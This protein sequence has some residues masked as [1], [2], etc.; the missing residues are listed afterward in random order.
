MVIKGFRITAAQGAK[1]LCQHVFRGTDNER[2]ILLRGTERDVFDMVRDAR[3]WRRKFGFRHFIV[4]PREVPTRD[5]F[6]EAVEALSAEFGFPPDAAVVVGH[7]KPRQDGESSPFHLHVFAPE[8]DPATGRVLSSRWSYARHE[9]V[10]RMLEA[11]WQHSVVPGRFNGPVLRALESEGREEAD[12]LRAEGL[13]AQAPRESAYPSGLHQEVRRRTG[14][15]MPEV[16]EAVLDA[17]TLS[18]GDAGAF[19][20]L[21]AERGLRVGEGDKP[22]RWIVQARGADGS[23]AFAG[24]LD[25]LLRTKARDVDGWVRGN[26]PAPMKGRE[27]NGGH[28]E[29]AVGRGGLL[30]DPGGDG[31]P[32]AAADPRRARA[33][34][35]ARRDLRRGGED[36][37]PDG[38]AGHGGGARGGKRAGPHRAPA[39]RDGRAAEG[40]QRAAERPDHAVL[41][42]RGPRGGVGAGEGGGRR[43]GAPAEV[44][45]TEEGRE[46]ARRLRGLMDVARLQHRFGLPGDRARLD[47][48]ARAVGR[49]EPAPIEGATNRTI[50]VAQGEQDARARRERFRLLLLKRAYRLDAWLPPGA[51]ANIRRVDWDETGARLLLTLVTGTHLLDTGDRITVRGLV[52]DVSTHEMAECVLRRGWQEVEVTGDPEFRVRMSRELMARGI[53]VKDCPL[54]RDEQARLR[55]ES[56]GFDWRTVGIEDGQDKLPEMGHEMPAPRPPWAA[57]LT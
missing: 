27:A 35:W 25:R 54:S 45:G 23:W 8:V 4:A 44:Q 1:G 55:R 31:G 24:S 11:R 32:G 21:L 6:D 17:R 42:P 14:R 40:H 15:R 29:P 20:R 13:A 19:H 9:K 33:H 12:Y 28:D 10:A 48:W 2:I 34:A 26:G 56:G 46:R 16:A 18:C 38:L 37:A 53:E 3:R 47:G 22:G 39:G 36:V 50:R 41:H 57:D 51:V 43:S 7:V 52:D 30:G 49:G 5:Q